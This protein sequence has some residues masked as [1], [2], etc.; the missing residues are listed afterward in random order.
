[1]RRRFLAGLVAASVAA[2]VAWVI[3]PFADLWVA[4]TCLG[5]KRDAS[6]SLVSLPARC[7]VISLT[8]A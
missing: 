7:S 8:Q 2:R 3:A 6:A 1:M 5:R 4:S